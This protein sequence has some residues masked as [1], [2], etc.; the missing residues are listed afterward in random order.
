MM[1]SNPKTAA[2]GIE[3]LPRSSGFQ[4]SAYAYKTYR[5]SHVTDTS[6]NLRCSF[7]AGFFTSATRTDFRM[8]EEENLVVPEYPTTTQSLAP[9]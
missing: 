9:F 6:E 8:T 7:T 3:R 4:L 1:L 2:A 5:K